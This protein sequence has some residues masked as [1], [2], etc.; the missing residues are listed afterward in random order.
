MFVV[1]VVV[2]REHVKFDF[3][4]SDVITAEDRIGYICPRCV[5]ATSERGERSWTRTLPRP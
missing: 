1:P 3:R 2:C 4:A 5:A